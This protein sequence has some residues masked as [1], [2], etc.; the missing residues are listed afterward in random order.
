MHGQL[1]DAGVAALQSGT[2]VRL[3]SA[4]L[5]NAFN[6][7]PDSG[8][9][10]IRGAEVFTTTPSEPMVQNANIVRYSVYLDFNVGP[11]QFGECALYLPDG[12][13]F[14][15]YAS[16]VMIKKL[17]LSTIGGQSN[18]IKLEI[19]V[20]MVG[21]NFDT[22]LD[23]AETNNKLQIPRINSVD[24]IP[25]SKDA[26]PN[27]Y[28]IPGADSTQQTILG[29]T[30][31][32]GLWAFDH[33]TYTS[34]VSARVVSATSL[35]ITITESDYQDDLSPDY[36]GQ[37][38]LQFST[39]PLFGI[40]RYV[41]SVEKV[42]TLYRVNFATPMAMLPN[43]G[44]R[45]FVQKRGGMS[46]TNVSIDVAT[47]TSLGVVMIGNYLN[48]TAGGK[49][50][51][52]IDAILEQLDL[53]IATKTSLGVVSIGKY[54]TVTPAGQVSIDTG[55][56]FADLDIELP[57]ATRNTTG[58]MSVGDYLLVTA[59]GKV[60]VDT[61]EL[62]RG[63]GLVKSVNTNLPDA[64]GNVTIQISTVGAS[65]K[66]EDLL[67]KPQPYSLPIASQT[68]L[69]GV[70][71]P[72]E[73]NLTVDSDGNLLL[74]F[75]PVTSV[76]GDA[77]DVVTINSIALTEGQNLNSIL[78]PVRYYATD[79]VGPTLTYGPQFALEAGTLEVIDVGEF[80]TARAKMQRWTQQGSM[81]VRFRLEN[82]TWQPWITVYDKETSKIATYT[83]LGVV[84]VSTGL[85]IDNIG[86]L[87][88]A[89][90]SINGKTEGDVVITAEELGAVKWTDVERRSGVAG[91]GDDPVQP[92]I[93]S[94]F[95]E[96]TYKR[97]GKDR[98]ALGTLVHTGTWNAFN[99][100]SNVFENDKY[101]TYNLLDEGQIRSSGGLAGT[102]VLSAYGKVFEV[103][104]GG[105][106]PLDGITDWTAGDLVIGLDGRWMRLPKPEQRVIDYQMAVS[107]SSDIIANS[108]LNYTRIAQTMT[109]RNNAKN[110]AAA[111]TPPTEATAFD[112]E[113]NGGVIGRIGFFA[114]SQS[115]S[116]NIFSP[117]DV[118][119]DDNFVIR[120]PSDTFGLGNVSII[121]TFLL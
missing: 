66:Y 103:A 107:A 41:E 55:E 62:I 93:D 39:G 119:V 40:C 113:L 4:K 32:Q 73:S 2:I 5:G 30:D 58:V 10:G 13:L 82:E 38:I 1:T 100:T 69:G 8:D 11:F 36:F 37:L 102:T 91:L 114:G 64:S 35:S 116:V 29:V 43:T 68:V 54:L 31:R 20:S 59:A 97:I 26:I 49:I 80:G 83:D 42:G 18:S 34:T 3:T 52:D 95:S 48:V 71:I 50:S 87:T 108:I 6:Y 7:I 51:V 112:I 110:K 89:I 60:S 96:Y 121:L 77:G 24:Q 45:F 70:K 84:K 63:L 28:V 101:Y 44:D 53:P 72:P 111:L 15:L 17:P 104:V 21:E 56:L 46:T 117:I 65:G 99:N 94:Y 88:T 9:T 25:P 98:T 16:D 67:D 76:N 90:S 78:D 27:V 81:A 12:E 33:Y 115:G 118:N 74:A 75:L 14:G 106:T 22:W 86:N 19:F 85:R 109:L 79:I 57:I 92:V 47:R 105:S 23:L 120:A 61:G